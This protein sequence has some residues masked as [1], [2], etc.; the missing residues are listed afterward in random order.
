MKLIH[1]LALTALTFGAAGNALASGA[2]HEDLSKLAKISEPQARKIALARVPGEVMSEELE[3]EH[4]RI[5]YSYDIKQPGKSGLEE[6]QVSAKS[7]KIVSVKH[8][9]D[10]AE[11]KEEKAH[12]AGLAAGR[13]SARWA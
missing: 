5:V 2:V 3:R 13:W 11:K 10:A 6:V 8:E 12:C 1:A 7:G 4:G 9:T